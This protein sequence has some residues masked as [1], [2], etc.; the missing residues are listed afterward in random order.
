[1]GILEFLRELTKQLA[2]PKLIA[3]I[4]FLSLVLTLVEYLPQELER[5][6]AKALIEGR[7]R[8][9]SG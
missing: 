4:F 8:P 3:G 2:K 5:S 6:V 7:T 9:Y 1:M